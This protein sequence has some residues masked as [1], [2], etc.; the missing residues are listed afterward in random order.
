MQSE[1]LNLKC[2]LILYPIWTLLMRDPA[3]GY[4]CVS[5]AS[6]SLGQSFLS[7]TAPGFTSSAVPSSGHPKSGG[8][9]GNWRG[10]WDR[11]EA[12]GLHREI[13]GSSPVKSV[14]GSQCSL[15]LHPRHLQRWWS[16]ALHARERNKDKDNILHLGSSGWAP[17]EAPWSS[18]RLN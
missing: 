3:L 2:R 12:H 14:T 4:I 9:G 7:L 5:V 18:S 8:W 10:F 17:G 1:I 6:V 15:R 13:E 16:R 11:P